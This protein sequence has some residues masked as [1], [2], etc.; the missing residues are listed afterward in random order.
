MVVVDN[1]KSYVLCHKKLFLQCAVLIN[2][3]SFEFGCLYFIKYAKKWRE[4]TRFLLF[5]NLTLLSAYNNPVG[6]GQISV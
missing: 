5:S 1:S 6:K 3:R 4:I 2:L